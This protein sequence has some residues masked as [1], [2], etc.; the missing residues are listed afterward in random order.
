MIK[1]YKVVSIFI[2]ICFL[3][4]FIALYNGVTASNEI[5]R[6]INDKI[7]TNMFIRKK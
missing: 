5:I 6:Q 3:S 7:N 4:A 1:R 2:I